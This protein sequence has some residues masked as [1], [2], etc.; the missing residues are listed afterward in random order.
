VDL[1]THVTDIAEYLRFEDLTDVVL[2][3]HSYA[4]MVITGAAARVPGRI[5]RLVYFDAFLPDEG[6]SALGGLPPATAEYFVRSATEQGDGWLMPKQSLEALGVRDET[7]KAWLTPRLGEHPLA[8]FTQSLTGIAPARA[9]PA[10]YL[11]CTDWA[12]TFRPQATQAR[13]LGWPVR[14]L[15][16]DHEALATAPGPLTEALLSALDD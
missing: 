6:E 10:T 12:A 2:V 7:A 13:A 3:G 11:V 15:P 8:C 4:G 9:L 14:D 1:A 5:R 16:T